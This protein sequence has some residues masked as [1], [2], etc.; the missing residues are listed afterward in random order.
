[1]ACTHFF[2]GPVPFQLPIFL[3]PVSTPFQ[4][5]KLQSKFDVISSKARGSGQDENGEPHSQVRSER[6]IAHA[7]MH[8]CALTYHNCLGH[9]CHSRFLKISCMR[10]ARRNAV[11]LKLPRRLIM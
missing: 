6:V 7:T 4:V 11:V 8:P 10:L 3:S 1:M 9:L 5:E 2:I